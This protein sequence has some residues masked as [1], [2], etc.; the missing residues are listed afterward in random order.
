MAGEATLIH[1]T[2]LPIPFTCADGTAIAKGAVL[3][4]TDPMTVVTVSG[5]DKPI[6]GIAA[7]EKVADDGKT[8]IAVYRRGIFKMLAG[9]ASI[10]IGNPL[11]S[12]SVANE[13]INADVNNTH[14]LGRAL[15]AAGDTETLLVDLNPIA[16]LGA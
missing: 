2:E 13:V 6:A 8:K 1:E 7:E 14:I 5:A 10:L 16:W 12:H 4:L 11:T 9:E 3:E 15:E